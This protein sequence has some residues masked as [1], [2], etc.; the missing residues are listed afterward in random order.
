MSKKI[1]R[2]PFYYGTKHDLELV[3]RGMKPISGIK[4]VNVKFYSWF[5]HPQTCNIVHIVRVDHNPPFEDRY[6]W[7][8]TIYDPNAKAGFNTSGFKIVKVA[9]KSYALHRLVALTFVENCDPK[10][11]TIVFCSKGKRDIRAN[12]LIWVSPKELAFYKKTTPPRLK[13]NL[14]PKRLK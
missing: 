14:I 5:I 4:G 11:K 12:N 1:I 8:M 9:G 7:T 6:V 2:T 10:R 13:L 3:L